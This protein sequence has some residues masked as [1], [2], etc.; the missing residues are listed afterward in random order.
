LFDGLQQQ[1]SHKNG[2]KDDSNKISQE[3][4]HDSPSLDKCDETKRN[5]Q[6]EVCDVATKTQTSLGRGIELEVQPESPPS[7]RSCTE[8]CQTQ[9][10]PTCF[11]CL[12]AA[13]NLFVGLQ[14]FRNKSGCK[15]E[16]N[17]TLEKEGY[18]SFY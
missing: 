15:Y 13:A 17:K 12:V 2:H 4:S 14:Q 6:H 1:D 7:R 8:S 10:D 9:G 16:Y 18:A 5:Q 3:N 11:K